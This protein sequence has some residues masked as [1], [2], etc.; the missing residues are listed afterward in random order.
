MSRTAGLKMLHLKFLQGI[1]RDASAP[2]G[3]EATESFEVIMI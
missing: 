1:M 3:A 2:G